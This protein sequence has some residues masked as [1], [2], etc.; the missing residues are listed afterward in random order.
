MPFLPDPKIIEEISLLEIIEDI[1][2]KFTTTHPNVLFEKASPLY[3]MA[4]LFAY[5]EILL[6]ARINNVARS[7][8]EQLSV[9]YAEKR[10]VAG[11][12]AYYESSVSEIA[13]ILDQQIIAHEN[14]E[15]HVHVL[16]DDKNK[17]AIEHL[18]AHLQ[19]PS[20]R[21]LNDNVII[22][23]AVNLKFKIK[24]HLVLDLGIQIDLDTAKKALMGKINVHL[25]IGRGLALSAIT[26]FLFRP[27]VLDVK[28]A[29][30][31]GSFAP[32]EGRLLRL[33]EIELS[34]GL[35]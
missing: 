5:R 28:I 12:L 23:E 17:M 20:K 22:K 9:A 7:L 2:A 26:A 24:A 31:P 18:R 33:E 14:G 34:Y 15:I 4:A 30:P 11:T 21:L 13:G 25:R 3:E 8:L 29:E 27:G 6:R 10:L 32:E 19:L 1:K 35:A 16:C